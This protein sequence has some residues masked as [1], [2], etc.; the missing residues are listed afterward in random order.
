M[1]VARIAVA[2]V[3]AFIAYFAIGFLAFGMGPLRREFENYKTIY[4]P[5]MA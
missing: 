4:R 3:A 5:R 1:N 2:S